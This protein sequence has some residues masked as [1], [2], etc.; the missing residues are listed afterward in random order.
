MPCFYSKSLVKFVNFFSRYLGCLPNSFGTYFCA[1]RVV[2]CEK[3]LYQ[4]CTLCRLYTLQL[5]NENTNKFLY[6]CCT[7]AALILQHKTLLLYRIS[8]KVSKIHGASLCNCQYFSGYTWLKVGRGGYARL[9]LRTS[10]LGTRVPRS[11]PGAATFALF[12]KLRK[13]DFRRLHPQV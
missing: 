13:R 9:A 10:G 11:N 1:T 3:V 12:A 6:H 4:T 8:N 7:G 5:V 2:D